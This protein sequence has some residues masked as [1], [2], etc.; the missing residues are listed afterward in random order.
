MTAIAPRMIPQAIP[1]IK[2]TT[3]L[4]QGTAPHSRSLWHL[5][6]TL[7]NLGNLG[8]IRRWWER[9]D[10]LPGIEVIRKDLVRYEHR[11][12]C[13]FF[14]PPSSNIKS[15]VVYLH[16]LGGDSTYLTHFMIRQL[17]KS[18]YTVICIDLEGHGHLSE[19]LWRGKD[20][21]DRK[22]CSDLARFLCQ[23]GIASYHLIGHSLGA[24]LA[25]LYA[26]L[27]SRGELIK[28]SPAHSPKS[29]SHHLPTIKSLTVL[30][31]PWMLNRASWK[32]L[33][34][35][36]VLTAP[37][38]WQHLWRLGPRETLPAMGPFLRNRYPLRQTFPTT[39]YYPYIASWVQSRP[40]LEWLTQSNSETLWIEGR[41]D[42]L[43]PT[44]PSQ[45]IEHS[46]VT[47]KKIIVPAGH[48]AILLCN[49]T[50]SA[51]IDHLDDLN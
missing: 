18:Q 50:L 13:Y 14:K 15:S 22:F 47:V 49:K 44:L 51:I 21:D 20:H 48:I 2:P 1:S 16:G 33:G 35:A 4:D 38:F 24:L 40:V 19:G 3:P 17:T 43:I 5:P 45:L 46:S 31:I 25:T 7:G 34:E 42:G 9:D 28:E 11:H 29:S 39:A 23:S 41:Y 6:K 30:N 26:Y 32:L 12:C 37:L 36:S 8:N 27:S 10:M